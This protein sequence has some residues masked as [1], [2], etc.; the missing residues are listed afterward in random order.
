MEAKEQESTM[1]LPENDELAVFQSCRTC[2]Y[3]AGQCLAQFCFS[4][5]I[6]PI[7]YL[8]AARVLEPT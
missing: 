6:N 7:I 8:N 5:K 2:T 1:P 4:N 3:S